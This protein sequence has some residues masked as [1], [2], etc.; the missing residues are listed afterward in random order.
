MPS[1]FANKGLAQVARRLPYLKRLP[2]MRLLALGEILVLAKE[3]LDKLE[4]RER[5]RLVVLLR[6]G[7]GRP[8]NLSKRQREELEALIAKAEPRLFAGTAAEKLSPVPLPDSVVRG[9][10]PAKKVKSGPAPPP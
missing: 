6:E 7:R 10:H 5:R 9:R 2:V 8:S 3:H 1:S 4:P